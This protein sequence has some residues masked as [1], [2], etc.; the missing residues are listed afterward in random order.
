MSAP[1]IAIIG[2]G[3]MGRA[4]EDVAAARNVPVRAVIDRDTRIDAASLAGADVAIE[5]TGPQSAVANARACVDAGCPVVVGSTGWSS[6][7]DSLVEHVERKGGALLW[8]PNFSLGVHAM[9]SIAMMAGMALGRLEGFDAHIVET[10]HVAKK[11][12]PS[13]TALQLQRAVS[14][15]FGREV[16]ITS[17]RVGSVPGTHEI[18]FDGAFEQVRMTHEVRDRR[19]FAEGALLAAQWLVGKRGVFTLDDALVR[20]PD[21]FPSAS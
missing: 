17:V 2:H 15:T 21:H 13:G 1:S 16:P 8:S 14:A 6:E 3:R 20:A 19:V 18:I 7:L 4:V 5:F 12:A 10:H 9:T 11:D